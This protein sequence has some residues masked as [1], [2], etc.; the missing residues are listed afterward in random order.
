MN[1]TVISPVSC[2]L[3]NGDPHPHSQR[4]SSSET[5]QKR[6]KPILTVWLSLH[7]LISHLL[8]LLGLLQ[9]DG[10][11]GGLLQTQVSA[12]PDQ[13]PQTWPAHAEYISEDRLRT[14]RVGSRGGSSLL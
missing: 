7:P 11:V 12:D 3:I 6:S 13:E 9:L 5:K 8:G 2:L 10:E 14:L 1:I 4:C